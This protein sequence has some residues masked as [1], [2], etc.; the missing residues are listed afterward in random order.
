MGDGEE[1]WEVSQLLFADYMVLV[2]DRQQ[3]EVRE[4]GEGVW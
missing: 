3:A 2:A 1:N 4:V